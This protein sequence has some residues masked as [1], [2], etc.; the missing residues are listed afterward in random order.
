MRPRRLLRLW[1]RWFGLLAS[2][3]LLLLA[4]TGSVIVFYDELDRL[5]NPELRISRTTMAAPVP[6][7]RAVT[8]AE[9]AL[10]GF[11]PRFIDLPNRQGDTVLMLGVVRASDAEPHPVQVFAD[12]VDGH[13]LGW[14][15]SERLRFDRRHLMDTL[16]SLH[17]DLMLGPWGVWFIGLVSLLWIMDHMVGVTLAVPRISAWASAFVIKSGGQ[18][19]KRL[20]DLH[21]APAMWLLPVTLVL[22]VSG[23]TL[24]WHDETRAVARLIAPVTERL[25]ENFP[26]VAGPIPT[27]SLD[28]AIT[29]A[30]EHGGGRTDS[31]LL[32]PRKGVYGVRGFD[33]RDLDSYGR[34]WTYIS[35][36]D[37]RVMGHRHD[38]GESPADIFFAWQYPLHSGKVFGLTGRLAI[39]AGGL[40]TILLCVS[41]FWLWQRRRGPLTHTPA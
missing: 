30:A 15:E 5:L 25:H 31:V 23:L 28:D 17:V 2:V 14:R 1:H 20:L 8:A 18:R 19:L 7:A 32:L 27:V 29:I 21:R 9:A 39:L 36:S 13:T 10:P 11:T 40:V 35:M 38:N 26:D 4:V 6:I 33:A 3:W 12:P 24:S 34:L 41:G 22:A 37:G 16:Y